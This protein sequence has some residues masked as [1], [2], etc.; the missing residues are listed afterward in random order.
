[1]LKI[2]WQL[3]GL[4]RI[5][6]FCCLF[7]LSLVWSRLGERSLSSVNFDDMKQVIIQ[8]PVPKIDHLEVKL[9]KRTSFGWDNGMKATSM[10]PWFFHNPFG[11]FENNTQPYHIKTLDG[12]SRY[13]QLRN[14]FYRQTSETDQPIVVSFLI[15]FPLVSLDNFAMF[16][17]LTSLKD[18]FSIAHLLRFAVLGLVD[19]AGYVI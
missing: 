1:M 10:I 16:I 4:F 14:S 13:W 2:W 15:Y 8:N 19:A 18:E 7:Q 17:L 5:D 11:S 12:N 3:F 9:F 6:M